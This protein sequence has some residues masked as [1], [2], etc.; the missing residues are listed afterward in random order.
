MALLGRG[1]AAMEA[2][3]R[4]ALARL[5]F[6]LVEL[7]P[8]N[9]SECFNAHL[10]RLYGE[11]VTGLQL[12]RSRPFPKNDNRFVEQK[13]DS[14]VRQLVGY[15]RLETPEQVEALN[16]LYTDMG[17]YYNLFQPV[18]RLAEKMPLPDAT[19]RA[20]RI[21]RR[22]DLAKTSLPAAR[23]DGP[24]RAG[25]AAAAPAPLQPDQPAR[26]APAHLPPTRGPMGCRRLPPPS[27]QKG[28][29]TMPR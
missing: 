26:P 17:V 29:T 7:H 25:A 27:A 18:L 12:S 4:T 14:L 15:Q 28:A 5:P 24:A 3:F 9:G 16:A 20:T 22:W 10:K 11:M 6:A 19:G 2:A 23:C 21:R 13:N 1:Q 8:N